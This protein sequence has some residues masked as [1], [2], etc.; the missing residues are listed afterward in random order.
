M[1]RGY[2]VAHRLGANLEQ[3]NVV[4]SMVIFSFLLNRRT[5]FTFVWDLGILIP[6]TEI[7]AAFNLADTYLH[8]IDKNER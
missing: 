4:F 1:A 7:M 6:R 8:L 2:V 5:S 3:G